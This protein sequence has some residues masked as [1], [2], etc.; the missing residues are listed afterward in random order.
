MKSKQE[1]QIEAVTAIITGELLLEEAMI[2]YNVKDKRT[3]TAWIKKTMPLLKTPK[4]ESEQRL[5]ILFNTVSE[6]AER[7]N[8]DGSLDILRENSL[9]KR[10]IVL[11]D[12]VR[13]LEE[14]NSLVTRHRDLLMEKVSSLELRIQIQQKTTK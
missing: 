1:L 6:T 8:H 2:K 5:D 10:I 11:Q 4:T 13:E 9:L 12:K 7:Y 3:M 14:K